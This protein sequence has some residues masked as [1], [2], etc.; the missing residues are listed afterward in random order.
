MS[1]LFRQKNSHIIFFNKFENHEFTKNIRTVSS[2]PF[3][4]V[5]VYM[6]SQGRTPEVMTTFNMWSKALFDSS[7]E[8]IEDNILR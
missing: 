1:G 7:S 8:G 4:D 6:R 5:E 3:S 2:A